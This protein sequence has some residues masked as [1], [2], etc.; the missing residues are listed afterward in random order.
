MRFRI[1]FADQIVG[2]FIILALLSVVLV[3]F[4]LG[5]RQRWFAKDYLYTAYFESATGLSAN[6]AVQYKGFTIGTV[7]SVRL[8]ET[9]QVEAVIAIF[10]SYADRIREGTIVDLEVSPIGL[11]NRFL[12]YPGLGT[13]QLEEGAILPRRGSDEAR[14]LIARGLAVQ[15]A[16]TDSISMLLENLNGALAQVNAALAG[17]DETSI[18]RV[19]GGFEGALGSIS[20]GAGEIRHTFEQILIDVKPILANLETFSAALAAPDGTAARV[21]DGQGQIYTSL[22]TSLNSVSSI[23]HNLDRTVEFIPAQLPQLVGMIA[24]LREV[25]TTMEGVLISLRNN[26][27][28]KNGVPEQVNNSSGGTSARDVSF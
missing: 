3:I 23:L 9:D 7:K 24:D 8:T 4:M 5:S 13:E 27:L 10:D 25:L 2:A 19:I 1:R 14:A 21:L 28:L 22:E 17:T 26:P 16:Q 12:L 11:G 15:S 6:M 20:D 18:G